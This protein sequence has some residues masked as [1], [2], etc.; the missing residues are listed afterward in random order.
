MIIE[1]FLE[2]IQPVVERYGRYALLIQRAVYSDNKGDSHNE[3]ERI[4]TDADLIVH[5]WNLMLLNH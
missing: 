3:V 5:D 4:F 1:H 2:E